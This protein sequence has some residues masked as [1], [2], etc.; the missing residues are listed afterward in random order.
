[1]VDGRREKLYSYVGRMNDKT[2]ITKSRNEMQRPRK[3]CT[4]KIKER[5]PSLFRKKEE[6]KLNLID[7]TIKLMPYLW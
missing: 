7:E 6:Q 4:G 2:T 5:F 1:M 3:K